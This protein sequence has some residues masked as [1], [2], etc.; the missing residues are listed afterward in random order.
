MQTVITLY[1]LQLCLLLFCL[2]SLQPS[3]A[4]I[5]LPSLKSWRNE[6]AT[7]KQAE[8]QVAIVSVAL[9]SP[10]LLS[11]VISDT[12]SSFHRHGRSGGVRLSMTWSLDRDG[13]PELLYR[14]KNETKISDEIFAMTG[15][16]HGIVKDL[17]LYNGTRL[18]IK[19]NG[20]G[21]VLSYGKS[22]F[23]IPESWRDRTEGCS[24]DYLINW[25]EKKI[26]SCRS[27]RISGL[28]ANLDI[29]DFAERLSKE[30][31]IGDRERSLHA[32]RNNAGVFTGIL[33]VET[34][35]ASCADR[36]CAS[37]DKTFVQGRIVNA[38]KHYHL[39]RRKTSREVA[40]ELEEGFSM[41]R[42]DV[43]RRG[44]LLDQFQSNAQVDQILDAADV[45]AK[46][47]C[48]IISDFGK[49]KN[50][51]KAMAVF[52]WIERS[53]LDPN[54]FHFNA[55]I[56]ACEKSGYWYTALLLL[57]EVRTRRIRP[58]T[59]TYSTLISACGKG[60]RSDLALQLFEEMKKNSLMSA[61]ATAGNIHKTREVFDSCKEK[62][63][64]LLLA[65]YHELIRSCHNEGDYKTAISYLEQ[66]EREG[67]K[68]IEYT[69]TLLASVC[70]QANR[71]DLADKKYP[72]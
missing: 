41:L 47:V 63:P 33:L 44:F 19:N 37:L 66:F 39:S 7:T 6:F 32:V 62:S 56:S 3:S 36:L 67:G 8:R 69:Y 28:P 48:K 25:M 64:A 52:I 17:G 21:P 65:F 23:I 15:E 4:F 55:I 34:K 68:P 10:I 24:R 2:N 27:V 11:P 40:I 18:V 46:T 16:R 26:S 54:L 58:D 1:W 60:K 53:K 42:P 35:D 43:S 20:N 5:R 70:N 61:Y 31:D 45:S 30:F 51:G 38:H 29:D 9:R 50:I 71:P 13:I 72:R 14:A 12:P 59:I 22:L 57:A 49:R